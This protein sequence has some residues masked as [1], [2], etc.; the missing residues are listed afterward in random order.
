MKTLVSVVVSLLLAGP[1]WAGGQGYGYGQAGIPVVTCGTSGPNSGSGIL[2]VP[3]GVSIT[4][5]AFEYHIGVGKREVIGGLYD[6]YIVKA[7][8]D[9]VALLSGMNRD[10]TAQMNV[11]PPVL[12]EAG[13]Q[14]LFTYECGGTTDGSP[15]TF[16][17]DVW[18]RWTP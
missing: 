17:P 14:V 3:V 18:L 13:D 6:L 15:M 10:G 9:R 11:I 2:P 8:G 12:V 5:A 7:N 4:Y 16:A 1:A